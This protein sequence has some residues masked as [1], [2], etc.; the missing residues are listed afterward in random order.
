MNLGFVEKSYPYSM[1]ERAKEV[2]MPVLIIQGDADEA[3]DSAAAER[4]VKIFPN[5]KLH[6]VKGAGH[7]LDVDGD[8]SEGLRVLIDFFRE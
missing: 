6:I 1:H 7:R 5:A 4:A 2:K 8:F 3:V